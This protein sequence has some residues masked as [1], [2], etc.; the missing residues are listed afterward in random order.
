M[1]STNKRVEHVLNEL[2]LQAT[3]IAGMNN[4]Y[5]AMDR[6]IS[7]LTPMFVEEVLELMNNLTMEIENVNTTLSTQLKSPVEPNVEP[8]GLPSFRIEVTAVQ[9]PLEARC[10]FCSDGNVKL[11]CV[12]KLLSEIPVSVCLEAGLGLPRF[13]RNLRKVSETMFVKTVN[14]YCCYDWNGFYDCF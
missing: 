2:L 6:I 10:P 7:E 5:T 8:L 9:C 4:T 3:Y 12:D 13:L 11:T 1:T 14:N